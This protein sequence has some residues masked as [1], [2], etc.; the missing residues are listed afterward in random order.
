MDGDVDADDYIFL[1][2][3]LANELTYAELVEVSA[4]K[5]E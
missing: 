3:Y 5:A 2:Q 4:P 1:A